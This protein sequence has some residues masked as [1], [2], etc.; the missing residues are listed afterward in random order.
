MKVAHGSKVIFSTSEGSFD[1]IVATEAIHEG[2]H[3]MTGNGID[4][5]VYVGQR[6]FVLRTCFIEVSKVYSA[7]DLSIFLTE[8]MLVSLVGCWMGLIK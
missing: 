1:F 5:Y 2:K 8:T 6:K 7:K 3:G 4:Q